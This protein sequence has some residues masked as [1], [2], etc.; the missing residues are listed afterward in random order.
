MTTQPFKVI[1]WGAGLASTTMAV[2]SALGD[3]P[4]VDLVLNCDPGWEP[5]WTRQTRA[6][7]TEWLIDHGM[8]VHIIPTG[9]I[10]KQGA[11]EH[12]HIPFWTSTGAPLNRQCSGK[13]KIR[14][15]QRYIREAIG[16]LPSRPPAP[17]AGAVEKW[18]G[19]TL[20]EYSR[21]SPSRLQYVIIHWPLVRLRMARQ[22]CVHYL[23]DHGLPVPHKSACIGCPYRLPSAWLWMKHNYPADFAEAVAFD[24]TNRHNPLGRRGG[25]TA[26]ELYVYK[27][28]V[29]LKDAPLEKD[30]ER[31]RRPKEVQLPLW[32]K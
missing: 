21:C 1:S 25:S 11:A 24:Q 29:P 9:D 5:T 22:D 17:P 13:F 31:E 2:M 32:L 26:D 10:R 15:A 27:Y 12:I 20:D 7:Y 3:L 6:F 8:N 30:A 18:I 23:Q 28:C 4:R 19:Y 16:F 14:P